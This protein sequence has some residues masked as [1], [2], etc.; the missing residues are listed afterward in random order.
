M[1]LIKLHFNESAGSYISRLLS[2]APGNLVAYWPLH[3]QAGTV[4]SDVSRTA[5]SAYNGAY[6]GVMLNQPGIGDGAGCPALNGTTSKVNLYSTALAAA[7]PGDEGTLLLWWRVADASVWTESW[8]HLMRIQANGSNRITAMRNSTANQLYIER[9][10]GGA[11]Q[12]NTI[13]GLSLT[14]WAHFG[15]TWSRAANAV[16][17]YLNGA[18]QGSTRTNPNAWAGALD[19][20]TTVLGAENTS[21]INVWRGWLAHAALFSTPLSAAQIGALAVA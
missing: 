5:P 2:A 12:S 9:A 18:Q 19:S 15:I 7:F 13:T 6:S 10:A 11:T 3:E 4:V 17:F 1:S 16:K 21:P 8:R 20:N 14:T